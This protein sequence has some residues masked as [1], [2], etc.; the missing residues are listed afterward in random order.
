VKRQGWDTD[1]I[2]F[3]GKTRRGAILFLIFFILAG[4]MA[5]YLFSAFSSNKAEVIYFSVLESDPIRLDTLKKNKSASFFQ[6]KKKKIIVVPTE[7][8][9]PN[10]LL[11]ED[12]MEMGFSAKQAASIVNFKDK[13]GGFQS[14]YDVAKVYAISD[15]I[16]EELKPVINLPDSLPHRAKKEWK[17]Y[18][19]NL[20]RASKSALQRIKGVGPFYAAR[21]V[22]YRDRLGGFYDVEQLMEINQMPQDLVSEVKQQVTELNTADMIRMDLN[23]VELGDLSRHPYIRISVAREIISFRELM[24]GYNQVEELLRLETINEALYEKLKHYFIVQ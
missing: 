18:P 4:V 1:W 20:N 17:N 22:E 11:S 5:R 3:S 16:F 6:Q 15:E 21:I 8:F 7:L 2:I 13:I 19:I 14:K 9:N 12:W 24:S 10:D 23:T